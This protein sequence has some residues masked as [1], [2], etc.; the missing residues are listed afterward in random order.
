M[1][2]EEVEET[3]SVTRTQLRRVVVEELMKWF[4]PIADDRVFDESEACSIA[5]EISDRLLRP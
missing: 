2:V 3:V 5:G 4:D 1:T